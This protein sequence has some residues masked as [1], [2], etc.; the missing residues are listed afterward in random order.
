MYATP[1][2]PENR[3]HETPVVYRLGDSCPTCGQAVDHVDHDVSPHPVPG[4]RDRAR[5]GGPGCGAVLMPCGHR[6]D[7][8][9]PMGNRGRSLVRRPKGV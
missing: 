6:M 9:K 2:N 4:T 5:I 3:P 1:S 8:V 7:V